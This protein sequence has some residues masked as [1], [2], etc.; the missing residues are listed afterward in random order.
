MLSSFLSRPP[1]RKT[2]AGTRVLR[3]T[4][5][6]ILVLSPAIVRGQGVVLNE[7]MFHPP[8]TNVLEQW[9]ELLNTG[10]GPMDLSGWKTTKGVSFTFPTNTQIAANGY[11]VVAADGPTFHAR[12]PEVANYVAGWIGTLGHSLD[13]S[14]AKGQLVTGARF[15]SEGDWATRVLGDSGVVGA[16]DAYG[17]LGWSWLAPQDGLGASLEL[18]NPQLPLSYAQNWGPNASTNSTPGQPNSIRSSDVAPFIS[19]ARHF[20]AIPAPADPIAIVCRVVDETSDGLVVTLRWRRDGDASFTSTPMQDDGAHG[21]ALPHDGVYGALLPPQANATIIEYSI[22][23]TDAL[24]HTRIYPAW[25]APADSTRTANLLLQ[26]DQSVYSGAQPIYR[27]IVTEAER[28]YLENL[29]NNTKPASGATTDSDANMNA[30]WITQDAVVDGGATTQ[31]RY[32]IGARNRG[33]GSRGARPHNFHANIPEDRSW[34]GQ[35]GINLNSQ[36]AHS[37]VLGSA[38]F[39]QLGIPMADARGVQLRLNGTNQMTLPLPDVNSHGSYTANE[40]YNN[41]FV[42]RSWPLDPA[43]NSYRGIRDQ[44]AGV[45]G[46]AD[47]TWHGAN[48]AQAA[49]TNA[50]YKQNNFVL[51]DWSDLIQLLGVLNVVSGYADAGSY[52]AE[53]EKVV[54][55]EEWMRFMAICALLDNDETSPSNGIGDDYALYRGVNDPRFLLLPYDL[56]TLMGRGVTPIP[57]ADHGLFR[58]TQLA[59]MDRFMKHPRFAPRY[60]YWLKRYSEGFFH[61]A[62]MNA[63]LDRLFVGWVDPAAISNMKAF[64]SARVSYV[65]SRIPARLTAQSSAPVVNGYPQ[66]TASTIALTGDADAIATSAVKVN[67]VAAQYS[68]WEGRWTNSVVNLHSGVNHVLVQAFDDGGVE[69]GSTN[70]DVWYDVAPKVSVSGT[71]AANQTWTAAAGPYTVA[72][73]LT[74]PNGV[75]LTI[76]PGA[77][78]YIASGATVQVNGTGRI[79]AEGK[80]AQRIHIGRNPAVAGNWGSL[81]FIN[82]SAESRLAYVDFDS[83]GGTTIGGHNAQIHANKSIVFVDHCSWPPTPVVEY[84]SFDASSFI[85]Q[86]CYFP[87]YPP[88]TGPESLHGINGI[89]AGGYGIFRDNYFGH[90]WGFNDTI[91][92]TG[93]NRPGPILQIL[94]NVFDG[95][96]DDCLDLDSTDAWIEGNVFMHVHRDPTRGDNAL[97]TGSAISGGVDFVGQNS[98]WT[99]INNLFYD[100]D[101]VFL[102]KGN[103]TTT[104]NGGGRVAFLYNTVIHVAKESSGSTAAEIAVFNWTDDDIALPD[105]SIGSGM[106]AAYNILYDYPA[107][108]R[109]YDPARHT[110]ILDHNILASPWAGSGVGNIVGDPRLDL[111]VLSGTPVAQVTADQLRRAAGLLPG[112]PAIGAGWGG[113]NAGGL[114]P[115]GVHIQGEPIGV[116]PLNS[117]TLS[118]GPAGTFTWGATA[119]QKWGW[120]AFKWRLDSGPWSAEIPVNN[121]PPFSTPATISLTALAAGDHTVSVIGKNDAGT[122]Q[123]DAFL[124]SPGSGIGPRTN[125]S[126]TWTVDPSHSRL[127]INEVLAK[128][129]VTLTNGSARPDLLELYNDGLVAIDLSGMGL[130]DTTNNPYRFAFPSGSVLAGGAYW[131]LYADS[132]TGG[133][134]LHTGFGLKQEGGGLFLYDKPARGGGLVDSVEFGFQLPDQSLGRMPDGQWRLC[135]PTFGAANK[136]Q[137][138]GDVRRL[139]INEWLAD[140]QFAAKNDFVELFNTDTLPIDMGG[141]FLSDS[142]GS[143]G[144]HRIASRSFIAARGFMSFI[145]DSDPLQGADH[146]SF[147]ISP[148][149]G[150]IL[151]SDAE[152]ET[153]DSVNYGPQ[154]TDVSEGRSP[155]GSA[156]FTAFPQPTPGGGNPGTQAGNCVI[157]TETIP[158]LAMG[159]SWRY[160]QTADLDGVNWTLPGYNDSAWPEGPA[161][162]A[163]EDCNCL[164]APGINTKL[165]LGRN[166]YYFRARFV[167]NSNLAGFNLNLTTV[168][169]DGAIVHLN[170][171]KILTNG[172]GTAAPVY[173]TL[174]SRNVGNAGAEFFSLSAAGLAQ[175]TNTLAVEV[176]QSGPSSTDIT[177]GMSLEATRSFTNCGPSTTIP[178]ALNEVLARNRSMTNYNGATADAIE[179]LNT[180]ST[181]INLDQMSL[182][183]DPGFP[184]KWV[185]PAASIA[186]GQHLVIY[187]DPTHAPADRNTGFGLKDHGGAVYLFNTPA[188]GGSLIDA[189]RYGL[190]VSDHSLARV[191][192]GAGNWTLGIPTL[193]AAN[194]ASGLASASVLKVNEWMADRASGPDW[195]ELYNPAAQPVALGALY[196]TDNLTD[197]TQSPISPLSFVGVAG[198]GYVVF[199]ADGNANA[200]PD[201]VN[202]SLKK[203]GE[204]IGIFS[205]TGTLIDGVTFGAQTTGVSQGRFPDGNAIIVGFPSS[206]S[207]GESNYQPLPQPVINETLTHTDPPL[208]DA[209]EFLNS[210]PAPVSIGGWYLS[211]SREVLKKYRIPDGVSVPAGGFA[212]FYENQFGTGDNAFTFNSAHGDSVVLSQADALGNLSGY[213]V[214]VSF[215]AAE[216]GVSF[217]RFPTSVGFDFA[218]LSARTFGVDHPSSIQEFITGA[219]LPNSGPKVGPVVVSEIHFRPTRNG[220]DYPDDQFIELE[221]LEIAPTPLFDPAASTNTWSLR[222]AVD[223]EFPTNVVLPAKGRLIVVGFDPAQ[224][225]TLAS[226]RARFKVPPDT[227]VLGPWSGALAS[228]TDSVELVK[229]DPIQQAPHPDA[230]FVPQVLVDRVVYSSAA[231]WPIAAAT[232]S[233]SLQRLNSASYGSDPANWKAASPTPGT[234]G[235]A[236]FIDTDGDG[237][238]DAWETSYFGDLSQSADDD[239]DHDGMTNLQE[240]LAGTDPKAPES[241]LK[242]DGV[243]I[244]LA[245]YHISFVAVAGRSY[246]IVYSDALNQQDWKNLADIPAEQTTRVVQIADP[247][248]ATTARFYRLV[249]RP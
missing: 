219:G 2:S 147:K 239:Y 148:D 134:F 102:N 116:T 59:V 201:H 181:S 27:V 79:L 11:L 86:G 156:L 62:E 211:N 222:N 69:I 18:I 183:D 1:G 106:Y 234:S 151:L 10:A 39:R 101:H 229:P 20:P 53:M 173:A 174:S 76:Q 207:P 115:F 213:R 220:V 206:P 113:R 221:N 93:G 31:L 9:F 98:D 60:Y 127:L 32:N 136:E 133:P 175:G 161:L 107:L 4:V 141:L 200:G 47:F 164:P 45:T 184:R 188:S 90:T 167:V 112:S 57:P 217:G 58:M 114:A 150:L 33:H 100:V 227:R 155:D 149:V 195:F 71:M 117:A 142:A 83:C 238:P 168:L 208:E 153:L 103:S 16:L 74:I 29:G 44:A 64:N 162:L 104:G 130:T 189:V 3:A 171:T 139:R 82:C 212:V 66:A 228:D 13:I 242:L 96:S 154:R 244:D 14:D 95:A 30:T 89:P 78:V 5:L 225:A 146:L 35:T 23:A 72:G 111:S 123:D 77:V 237:L 52:V 42:K 172:M 81:D 80:E 241:R 152:L 121:P 190:Q 199:T 61:P 218:A 157:A 50:Y 46:V 192:D 159:A 182:T 143:P 205:G 110:V 233:N 118:F 12:H 179:L 247:N 245:G 97:D 28:R 105:A 122:Y 6:L 223:F 131:I 160:N 48:I 226:F 36:Y 15:Y 236:T 7:V 197:K 73:N 169:D 124:Y 51:N 92:F 38:V 186:A 230:G 180:G 26:V 187:C 94:N 19:E 243:T 56:D 145:A 8:G 54:D 63:L 194:V 37:Q 109:F 129:T 209:V 41:D 87:T 246:S 166:T 24:G 88:P 120:T 140:A 137:P 163:V 158:L 191:P 210:G 21:D 55:V 193:G 249:L 108:Q 214:E 144:R 99:I 22:S 43:G 75:T 185:A 70:I 177:W 178:I 17:G 125:Y 65:L 68:A 40:Q 232:G 85:V 135:V 248:P 203:S 49:Y 170:G 67:G 91:D 202:F 84:I 235:D 34:K 240:F 176:H 25:I 138:T 165:T 119:A 198:D 132:A 216:N 126:R 204:A 215:G 224:S 128:N 231:P 196:L